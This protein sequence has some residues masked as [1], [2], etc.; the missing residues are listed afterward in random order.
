MTLL[1]GCQDK[2]ASWPVSLDCYFLF[3]AGSLL[4]R[5]VREG[6]RCVLWLFSAS[7]REVCCRILHSTF[8]LQ[9]E[10]VSV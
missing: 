2:F 7:I 4:G 3:Y 1:A 10:V 8:I 5:L 9:S 6:E